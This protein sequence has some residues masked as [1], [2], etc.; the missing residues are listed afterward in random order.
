LSRLLGQPFHSLSET[1]GRVPNGLQDR[2]QMRI[3][4]ISLTL[5]W[6]DV[7]KDRGNAIGVPALAIRQGLD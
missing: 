1:A 6:Q 2:Y 4:V 3:M 5:L 7:T